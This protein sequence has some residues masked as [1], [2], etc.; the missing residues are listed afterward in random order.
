M[1][2]IQDI[3]KNFFDHGVVGIEENKIGHINS[4][5]VVD[6][7][8]SNKVLLQKI[9]TNVFKDVDIVMNNIVL[10][11]QHIREKL[12]AAGENP[13]R[14]V[15]K[16]YP[17][18]TGEYYYRDAQDQCWRVYNFIDDAKTYSECHDPKLFET[19]GFA[20][21]QFVEE[22]ADFGASQLKECIPDFHNTP[23]RL[24]NFRKSLAKDKLLR[25][26]NALAEIKF[27]DTNAH[28]SDYITGKLDK[29]I[30]PLRVTHN[31][32]KINNIMIDNDTKQ[33]ICVVDLDTIMPGSL[34]YDFGDAI[35]SG[36]SSA[37]ED[38]AD[39]S[40][41]NFKL[42]MYEAYVRGTMKALG[43]SITAEE[44]EGLPYGAFLMTFEC[45]MRF[46]TDYLDGDTYFKI[47]YEDH[48]LVRTKNQF[49][50]CQD[51]IDIFKLK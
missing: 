18:K 21:A 17:T 15:L 9:N 27:I 20:F 30:L 41:V 51:M 47:D 22:L 3:L 16:V 42:E 5:Y 40:K 50:L 33:P 24:D 11:T 38:E 39:L 49:K 31:D 19:I 36:A 34:L 37:A 1:Q 8:T 32:T 29:G 48:N 4:T 25:A 23:K 12:E 26:E 13:S 14:R 28:F 6:L 45:G 35:R 43:D 46:L 2:E 10:C 7:E 44:I